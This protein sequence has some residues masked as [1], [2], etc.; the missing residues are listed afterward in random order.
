MGKGQP[1]KRWGKSTRGTGGVFASKK[2]R[3]AAV[4]GVG[5]ESKSPATEK[6]EV[7][8]REWGGV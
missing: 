2:G 5:R 6:S 8:G 1:R 7:T 4:E 3:V